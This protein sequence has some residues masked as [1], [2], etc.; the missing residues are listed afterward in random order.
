MMIMMMM[1]MMIQIYPKDLIRHTRDLQQV[2]LVENQTGTLED[3]LV[4]VHL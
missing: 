2:A 1:M 4:V 3:R